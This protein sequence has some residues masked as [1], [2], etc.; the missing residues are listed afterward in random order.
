MNLFTYLFARDICNKNI[1]SQTRLVV[2]IYKGLYYNF[3]KW[4]DKKMTIL[5]TIN[6]NIKKA[7][8]GL[9][10]YKEG[11]QTALDLFIKNYEGELSKNAQ[12]L[13]RILATVKANDRKLLTK[14]ITVL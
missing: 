6:T 8:T 11:I 14:Y 10:N 3:N 4:K 13:E 7:N 1:G 2:Y 12:P 5:A 9:K